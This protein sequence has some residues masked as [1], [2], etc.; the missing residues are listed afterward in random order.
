MVQRVGDQDD[1]LKQGSKFATIVAHNGEPLES[2]V[3][4]LKQESLHIGR[5]FFVLKKEG[6]FALDNW[7]RC[8]ELVASEDRGAG[9]SKF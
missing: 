9:E 4:G 3:P 8:H 6:Q 7:L 5:N 2:V 1:V